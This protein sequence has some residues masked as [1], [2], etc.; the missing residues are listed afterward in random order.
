MRSS[1]VHRTQ[2]TRA[3][4]VIA[5]MSIPDHTT[6]F[7]YG[8][9]PQSIMSDLCIIVVDCAAQIHCRRRRG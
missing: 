9:S 5:I 1:A 2:A 3:A 4:L 7:V 8:D 6:E